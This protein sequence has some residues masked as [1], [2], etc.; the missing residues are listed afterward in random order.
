M[1]LGREGCERE[2]KGEGGGEGR[3]EVLQV[4]WYASKALMGQG[5]RGK[6]VRVRAWEQVMGIYVG[7]RLRR[8]LNV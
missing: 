1:G 3:G 6:A 5:F 7:V 2:R 8:V 4:G